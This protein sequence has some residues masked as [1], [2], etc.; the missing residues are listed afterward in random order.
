MPD[1]FQL[2]IVTPEKMVVRDAAEEMQIPG[3]NGYLGIL[4]G[5]APLI[6]ELAVG[7]ISYR[8]NGYT[9]H[10]AVAWGFAEVLPDKVTILA[11]TAERPE[12]IDAKR[13]QEAKQ[14]AEERLKSGSTETDY[15]RAQ[16][17]LQRA[18]TRLQVAEKKS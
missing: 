16:D 1:T 6:T 11:E 13:A 17:A 12:E 4:P 15:A 2:E 8:N 10:L 5:H 18:E 9:H 14:R 3:K 7:E